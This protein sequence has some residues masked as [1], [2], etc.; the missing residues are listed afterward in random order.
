[1]FVVIGSMGEGDDNDGKGENFR[2]LCMEF[3][4]EEVS[5]K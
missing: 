1:M 3:L 4:M 5:W 2:N